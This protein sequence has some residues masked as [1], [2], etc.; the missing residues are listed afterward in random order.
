M[1]N[2]ERPNRQGPNGKRL[3]GNGNGGL[4]GHAR[5]NANGVGQPTRVSG[6]PRQA[7]DRYLVLAREAISSGDRITAEG[8]L[9]HA[10]HFYRVING[11]SDQG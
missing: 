3:R 2:N 4:N 11:N 8:Y 6:N 1:N 7:M 10:E 5:R 9:Q